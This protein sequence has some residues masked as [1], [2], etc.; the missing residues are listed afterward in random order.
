[1]T[2]KGD[3]ALL[4]VLTSLDLFYGLISRK[5]TS[6]DV[7][8]REVTKVPGCGVDLTEHQP[9]WSKLKFFCVWTSVPYGTRQV[10]GAK[11]EGRGQ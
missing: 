1:M 5:V 6:S 9:T 3:R 7:C 2:G 4:T 11:V 10:A 8:F